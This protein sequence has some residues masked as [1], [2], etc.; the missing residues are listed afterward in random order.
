MNKLR[1]HLLKHFNP[2]AVPDIDA[3]VEFH[4][5]DDTHGIRISIGSGECRITDG[6]PTWTIYL[7]NEETA[8]ALLQSKTDPIQLFME[9]KL[10]SSGYIVATFR[11]LRAFMLGN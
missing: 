4:L 10:A 2:E 6:E 9:Q 11:V 7:Q 1:A 8:L 5:T 3:I